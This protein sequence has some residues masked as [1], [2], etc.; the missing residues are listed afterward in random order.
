MTIDERIRSWKQKAEYDLKTAEA[1]LE[2]KRYVYVGFM[3][4]QA[5]E[6]LLKAIYVSKKREEP[7]YTH[8]LRHLADLVVLDFPS[9]TG[10]FFDTLMA[11]YIVG[12]YPS[13]KENVAKR[14]TKNSSVTMLKETEKIFRWLQSQLESKKR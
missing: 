13:Y 14:L 5:L 12:R 1:M 4:Q 8:N 11:Y 3:C 7:P 10:R 2:S 6:K 9:E